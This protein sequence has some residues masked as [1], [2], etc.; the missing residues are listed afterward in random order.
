[1]QTVIEIYLYSAG[2][3][4]VIFFVVAVRRG[5]DLPP[6]SAVG[7]IV[8]AFAFGLLTWTAL[9]TLDLFFA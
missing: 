4:L 3:L 7:L 8:L 2:W 6:G 9:L 5:P 1:M